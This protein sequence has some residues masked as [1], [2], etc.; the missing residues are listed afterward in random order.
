MKETPWKIADGR[1]QF[2]LVCYDRKVAEIAE[3]QKK[4]KPLVEQGKLF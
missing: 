3:W 1:R 4:S 2:C